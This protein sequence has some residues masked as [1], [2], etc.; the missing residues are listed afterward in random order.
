MSAQVLATIMVLSKHS[1]VFKEKCFV[2]PAATVL[3]EARRMLG[4]KG[5]KR[6]QVFAH[7]KPGHAD[8]V[9]EVQL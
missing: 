4:R 7:P 6:L 8:L 3:T 5:V 2:V 9:G 1:G